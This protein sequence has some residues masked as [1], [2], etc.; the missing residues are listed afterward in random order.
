MM[1]PI[2]IAAFL[3][4]FCG[5]AV[6]VTFDISR[7]LSLSALMKAMRESEERPS[8]AKFDPDVNLNT[9]QMIRK[10]GYPAEAHVIQTKDGYLLTLHRIPGDK[11]QPPVLLQHGFLCSSAD[12]VISG[13]DKG[14][15]F[16]LADQGYDVWLGNIRGNTYSRAHVSLSPSDSKFWNFSFHEMGVYDLP[17]MILYITNMTSQPLHT[18]IGHSMGSTASY[19]MATERP[20]IARMVRA[21]ISLAPVAFSKHIK[22]PIRIFAPFVNDYEIIAH[23]LGE[24][25]FLPRNCVLRFLAK[26]VC[27]GNDFEKEICTNTLFLICG[28][29]KEQFNYTLLPVILSHDPAGASTKTLLHFG[30]EIESGKFRQYDYGSEKNLLI[31]NATEPPDYN[32]ANITVPIALFYAD[33]DWL[34]NSLDVKK[35]YSMLPNVLDLYRVPFP[36]FNHLDFIWGKDAFELV[37]KRLLEIMKKITMRSIVIVYLLSL[38]GFLDSAPAGIL[39]VPQEILQRLFSNVMQTSNERCWSN[40]EFTPPEVNLSIPQM[41]QKA[42]FPAEAHIVQTEDGYLLTLYRIPGNNSSPPVLLQHGLLTS[43][44]DWLI[45]GRDKGLGFVLA[46]QGYDVW[47]GNFRGNTY[48][49]A[50]ICLS[51]SD[52]RFWNF[53][54]HEM[55]VYD[56]PAMISYITNM[57][58]QPLHTYLGHSMGTTASYVMAAERPEIAQMVRMIISLSPVAF[59]KHMRSPIRFLTPFANNLQRILHYLGKDEFL[60]HSNMTHFLSKTACDMTR[61]QEEIC[62]N[63]LF[64]LFGF[65][66]EQFNITLMSEI[67][68]YN[69]AGTSTKTLVH[70]AQEHNSGKFCQ[71]DY[72]ITKNLQIYNA[73][74]PPSYN[75]ANITTPFALFYSENDWLSSIPDVKDLIDLLP[76]VVDEYKVP[77]FN[78]LDFLWATD[79]PQFVY[80]RLLEVM[81]MNPKPIEQY[82]IN[83]QG[84]KSQL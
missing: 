38:C 18:Y 46:D 23:F 53:S 64:L 17:A 77:K 2:V 58:S 79:A 31:Y 72:G 73:A 27:E 51:P 54:F 25:E 12:W 81:K 62:T 70:L 8:S 36:K 59:L 80:K 50:H 52:S 37:Y 71:Y 49:R 14:L 66:R 41:I 16:I 82:R 78:H 48:S 67:V 43:F 83:D 42:G 84:K 11:D 4:L 3:L 57:T 35:L 5:L 22:S 1:R 56:L 7:D 75:L 76:N 61:I 47:L 65:D 15:A 60:P 40:N 32:L 69:P 34:A 44:A 55:G 63:L 10:A 20:D 45:P 26:Y 28:F 68:N 24:N 33:N 6:A 30:Q 39:G 13:K 21:I 29:D 74:E 19:V 9:L